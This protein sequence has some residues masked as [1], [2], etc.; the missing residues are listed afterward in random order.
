[1]NSRVV[2]RV[3]GGGYCKTV[4]ASYQQ[5]SI[6]IDAC[7]LQDAKRVGAQLVEVLDRE[8]GRIYSAP[9]DLI[10]QGSLAIRFFSVTEP[11]PNHDEQLSLFR[12]AR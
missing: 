2:G 10:L 9:I 7:L 4:Q 12:G 6:T 3:K 5:D 11:V 1:M 8:T